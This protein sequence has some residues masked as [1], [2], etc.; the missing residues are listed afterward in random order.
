M[1]NYETQRIGLFYIQ[2]IQVPERNLCVYSSGAEELVSAVYKI[3]SDY[4]FTT[5]QKKYNLRRTNILKDRFSQAFIEALV[6]KDLAALRKVP[7]ADLHNHFSL[8]GNRE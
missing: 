6:N 3:S 8:G 5:T 2:L 4:Y 1:S 7:K